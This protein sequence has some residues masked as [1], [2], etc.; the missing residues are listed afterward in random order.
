MAEHVRLPS[1]AFSSD[2]PSLLT[3]RHVRTSER[4]HT[5]EHTV[6]DYR[7]M[8]S[9]V[10]ARRGRAC[11]HPVRIARIHYPRFVP[12]VGSGFKEIRTLSALIISKGRV[13][14]DPNLGLRT[15]YLFCLLYIREVLF[16]YLL[17]I[18]IYIHTYIYIY[19]YTRGVVYLCCLRRR[20]TYSS[21]GQRELRDPEPRVSVDQT[22]YVMYV[23]YIYIYIY[24]YIC[25]CI[26]IYIYI[27][28]HTSIWYVVYIYIYIYVSI[29][30][31]SRR[32]PRR[33]SAPPPTRSGARPQ[34]RDSS[35]TVRL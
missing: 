32:S 19:I 26:Y 3:P 4:R 22:T 12:T 6:I 16:I 29:L 25:L 17:Y 23:I 11:V 24:I 27:Y 35:L 33:T 8:C 14:K 21:T 31:S 5:E 15:G 18:Y 30:R 7:Q 34:A 9:M 28:T 10:R 20:A 13:R 2:G 1:S